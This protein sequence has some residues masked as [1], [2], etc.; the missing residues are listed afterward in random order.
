MTHLM[1]KIVISTHLSISTKCTVNCIENHWRF[2]Y[3]YVRR[4][5][6]QQIQNGWFVIENI[7]H[8][9]EMI[10]LKTGSTR[11]NRIDVHRRRIINVQFTWKCNSLWEVME[12]DSDRER[13]EA[14]ITFNFKNIHCHVDTRTHELCQCKLCRN[15]FV[16]SAFIF[17]LSTNIQTVNIAI[18]IW[19]R[20]ILSLLDI[21][22]DIRRNMR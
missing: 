9:E 3:L 10:I 6:I 11:D 4:Q 13:I 12:I 8:V 7:L 15:Q 5:L 20:A 1:W 21:S 19:Q 17:Q 18:D 2:A 14:K 16:W 22:H